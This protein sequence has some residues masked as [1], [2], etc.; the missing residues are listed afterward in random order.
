[1][2]TS[3]YITYILRNSYDNVTSKQILPIESTL[4]NS[5]YTP[6]PPIFSDSLQL[7]EDDILPPISLESNSSIDTDTRHR[8]LHIPGDQSTVLFVLPPCQRGSRMAAN[9]TT[10]E[11]I[12]LLRETS[13]RLLC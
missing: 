7:K 13:S 8:W 10:S 11:L 3:T 4:N 1:M 12:D 6:A 2:S 5:S 9:S